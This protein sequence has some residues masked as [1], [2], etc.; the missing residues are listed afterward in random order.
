VTGGYTDDGF[1]QAGSSYSDV[2]QQLY[3]IY[4]QREREAAEKP[5]LCEIRCPW[6][7]NLVLASTLPKTA[8]KPWEPAIPA[9]AIPIIV[10]HAIPAGIARLVYNDGTSKDIEVIKRPAETRQCRRRGWAPRLLGRLHWP[11]RS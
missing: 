6:P 5:Y 8:R 2:F 7:V 11:R 10:D 3:A 4:A 9:R 1:G